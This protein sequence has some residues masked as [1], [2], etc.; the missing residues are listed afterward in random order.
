MTEVATRTSSSTTSGGF[1]REGEFSPSQKDPGSGSPVKPTPHQAPTPTVLGG[2]VP[3]PAAAAAATA[4]QPGAY[5]FPY[6]AAHP[7]YPPPPH[8]AVP[9]AS[10]FYPAGAAAAATPGA[11]PFAPP[12][13]QP[14]AF[15]Y[16]GYPL[17]PPIHPTQY[18]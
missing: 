6:P 16:R 12:P 1:I 5:P 14:Y 10:P 11:I 2:A 13:P 15:D 8:P 4:F 18:R 3:P 17:Y 9:H 7:F